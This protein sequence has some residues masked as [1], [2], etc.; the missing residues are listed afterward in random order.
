MALDVT[1]NLNDELEAE[2]RLETDE[3]NAVNIGGDPLSPAQFL[4]RDVRSRLE[5]NA[6]VRRD[7]QRRHL[8][9]AYDA[10]TAEEQA[11][12]N[13]ILDKYRTQTATST[14]LR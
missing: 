1:I 5:F 4:R 12:I 10:A 2:L 6:Q 13:A 3:A 14:R 9:A 7:N 8:R 11:I